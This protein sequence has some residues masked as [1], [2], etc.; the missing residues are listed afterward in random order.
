[1]EEF[2]L[3]KTLGVFV[4]AFLQELLSKNKLVSTTRDTLC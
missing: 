1:M 4:L 3:I 2:L